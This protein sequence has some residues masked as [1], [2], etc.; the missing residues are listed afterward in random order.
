[1]TR[2]RKDLP[3]EHEE[4]K[5]PA[6]ETHT[7]RAERKQKESDA[8][9]EALKETFPTSDPVSPFVPAIPVETSSAEGNNGTSRCA[10]EKC[11][12]EVTPPQQWC[13]EE[14]RE[15]QQGCAAGS[16]SAC[17]CGHAACA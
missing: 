17:G 1:M 2:D 14:C 3:H 9:D 8:L 12:C 5:V 11:R 13:S 15:A 6:V 4:Q 7:D 16:G 10:H